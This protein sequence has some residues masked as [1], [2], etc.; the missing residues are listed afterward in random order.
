M[1]KSSPAR[2]AASSPRCEVK[3]GRAAEIRELAAGLGVTVTA[4]L[5]ALAPSPRPR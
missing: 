4:E 5:G 3:P 2:L 1:S